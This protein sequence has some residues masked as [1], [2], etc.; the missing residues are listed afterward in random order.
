LL[1]LNIANVKKYQELE[2]D[3]IFVANKEGFRLHDTI[4]LR[5]SSM[6]GGFKYEPIFIFKKE[7]I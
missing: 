3:A 4:K 2:Q 1:M 5:L 7:K 6:K